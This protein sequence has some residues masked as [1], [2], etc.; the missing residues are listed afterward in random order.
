MK[1][2]ILADPFI[3]SRVITDP[4]LV[5][6]VQ[7]ML[8]LWLMAF[9][10]M[11]IEKILATGVLSETTATVVITM[12]TG[13]VV[14][15]PAYVVYAGNCQVVGAVAVLSFA[16]VTFLKLISYHMVNYWCRM[17]C[18][19]RSRRP[20]KLRRYRSFSK[21][22]S[23]SES[24]LKTL[25]RTFMKYEEESGVLVQYPDNLNARDLVYFMLVPTL[26]YE[27]NFPRSQRIR[28][29]FV[30][31]RAIEAIFL[32]QLMLG[33]VQ[34]WLF[35]TIINSVGPLKEMNYPKMFE[36]LLKLAVS[37]PLYCSRSA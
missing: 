22:N 32:S 26:C 34:Q 12:H 27:L 28:K 14:I 37:T 23:G 2:G 8:G 11:L 15:V 1:Y 24:N 7:L 29:R 36:R 31:R 25:S 17:E 16:S 21:T 33:L 3:L 6:C 20:S 4:T 35:P 13:A 9:I 10:S 18:P 30:F 19:S 5:P